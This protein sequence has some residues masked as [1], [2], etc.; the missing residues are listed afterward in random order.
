MVVSSR[1]PKKPSH[2]DFAKIEHPSTLTLSWE[3]QGWG[4]GQILVGS[5]IGSGVTMGQRP[6]SSIPEQKEEP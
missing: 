1:S 4:N 3:P 6:Y 2:E 5:P